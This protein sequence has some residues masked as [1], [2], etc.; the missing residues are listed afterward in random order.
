LNAQDQEFGRARIARVLK[1]YC[2]LAPQALV[3]AIFRELD[4]YMEGTP[5]TDDQTAIAIRVS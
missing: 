1:K 2:E 4:Q 5:I 3:E